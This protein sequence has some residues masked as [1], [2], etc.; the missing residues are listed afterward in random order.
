MLQ[1][2]PGAWALLY[3]LSMEDRH[4][5]LFMAQL[6]LVY[7]HFIR[8]EDLRDSPELLA[9]AVNVTHDRL[10]AEVGAPESPLLNIS[11]RFVCLKAGYSMPTIGGYLAWS[12]G[13]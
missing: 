7:E 12:E 2:H 8:A 9:L 10:I 4:K 6:P 5:R 13:T 3:H 1:Q 11:C